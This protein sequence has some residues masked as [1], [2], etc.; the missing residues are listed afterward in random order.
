MTDV[1]P[2]MTVT[3]KVNICTELRI[4]SAP[5][6]SLSINPSLTALAMITD[7]LAGRARGL[8]QVWRR[9]I[10]AAVGLAGREAARP[11]AVP[12]YSVVPDSV[13]PRMTVEDV[14][15]Q[16]QIEMLHDMHPS[17]LIDDLEQT[18]GTGSPPA[19]WRGVAERPDQ[20]L[21]GYAS[22]LADV[23]KAAE[24]LWRRARPLLDK[25]IERVG[26]AAV[27]GGQ[28]LLLGALSDRIRYGEHG[29]LISDME[30]GSFDRGN[31]HIVLLPMLAGRRAVIARLDSPDAVWIAYPLSG[32]EQLWHR[33]AAPATDQLSEL[34]GPIRAEVLFSLDR[35]MTMSTLAA[36]IKIAHSS[37][38]RYCH[39][40][41]AAQ[42]IKRQRRGREVWIERTERAEELIHLFR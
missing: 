29:L 24:P 30:S 21:R 36:E 41:H 1:H 14:S 37:M 18:F 2:R 19:H 27:R 32:A 28:E 33:S 22:A 8:P 31:R 17:W 12:G 23:W 5:R 20:W 42:L 4:S 25:E 10:Q 34:I 3:S 35:P 6:L 26:I 40:L 7:A 9:T 39:R 15:V 16:A 11:L 13:V 38:T